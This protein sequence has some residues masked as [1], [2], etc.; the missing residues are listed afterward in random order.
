MSS[1]ARPITHRYED[2]LAQIWIRCAE[3][4]GFRVVRSPEVF[5]SCDGAGTLLIGEAATLD[6]DDSL[7][8]MILHELC[9]ALIEGDAGEARPDWGLDNTSRRDTWH[10]HACLRLQAYLADR[11]GLRNFF[12]PT[13]MFR[14]RFWNTLPEDPFAAPADQ[15][16][17]REPSCVAA[18]I[19]AWRAEQPRWSAPLD[20]ALQ[21]TAAI[22]DALR[23]SV[24]QAPLG[25]VPGDQ[26]MPS[27]WQSAGLAPEQ[28]PAGHAPLAAYHP[29][30]RCG[31]CAWGFRRGGGFRCRHRPDQGLRPE[32][33]ACMRFEPADELN[34]ADC[35]A[36]CREAYDAVELSPGDAV[37]RRHPD[38]IIHG[39]RRKLRRNGTR[40]IALQGGDTPTEAFL[41]R[42]YA[43]R[44]RSCR[45]FARGGANCLDARRRVGLSL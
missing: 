23:N 31:D 2:P 7:G 29:D 34:C 21:A 6:A 25:A 27:L 36:C 33:P 28:H 3:Q 41:C 22:A 4:T 37:A 11:F 8:Q 13:T 10:E 39:T 30:R 12:A 44:P 17:R 38:L 1:S 16:G 24:V 45:E 26:A 40:C 19:G 18:R 32:A 9:H 15:G 43:D 42:I 35:G 14:T 5:A 20:A